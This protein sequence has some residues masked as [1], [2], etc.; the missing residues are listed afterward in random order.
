[1]SLI[2][3]NVLLDQVDLRLPGLRNDLVFRRSYNSATRLRE[4]SLGGG[5]THY[6]EKTMERLSDY[7]IRLWGSNGVAQYFTDPDGDGVFTP[8]AAPSGS[9]RIHQTPAGLRREFRS[10]GYEAY[11]ADGK[12]LRRT[13]RTGRSYVMVRNFSGRLDEIVTPE[14]RKVKFERP[15]LPLHGQLRGKPSWLWQPLHGRADQR[16]P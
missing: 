15:V 16:V 9:S 14:G 8:Y 7:V 10:G 12:L 1:V 4:G 3:G 13:D 2:T 5:W 6:F 11:G